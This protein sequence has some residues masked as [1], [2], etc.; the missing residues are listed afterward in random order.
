MVMKGYPT[1][2]KAPELK[3]HHH[4][5][6][7]VIPRTL[8]GEALPHCKEAVGVFYSLAT[9]TVS[10]YPTST[11]TASGML[12]VGVDRLFLCFVAW[13]QCWREKNWLLGFYGISTLVG[14]S[15][16]NPVYT[17]L[18]DIYDLLSHFEDNIFKQV[19]AHFCSEWTVFRH[20]Y[21]TGTI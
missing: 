7:S 18:L 8:I 17:Y 21:V 11:S 6:F 19:W 20:C 10:A 14:Y 16:P 12:A 4:M 15:M 3:P 5:Q 1:S 13:S 2:P 9:A